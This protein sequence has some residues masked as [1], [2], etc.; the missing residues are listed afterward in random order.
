MQPKQ[1]T[2]KIRVEIGP[3]FP[4]DLGAYER[5]HALQ[6]LFAAF[7]QALTAEKVYPESFFIG[8][9]NGV[10][11]HLTPTHFSIGSDPNLPTIHHIECV[12]TVKLAGK[13][14]GELRPIPSEV[15]LFPIERGQL[16]AMKRGRRYEATVPVLPDISGRL[17]PGA[18]A[19]FYE[20]TANPLSDPIPVPEGDRLTV[21][22]TK[23][24]DADYP[25]VGHQL[26]FIAWD[27]DEAV[28][29]A[30]VTSRKSRR[31]TMPEK[32]DG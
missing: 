18:K 20:A 26:F 28:K 25:W 31:G 10:T 24:K 21:T 13:E 30:A 22:L 16:E 29:E 14:D 3:G 5:P 12:G 6:A 17:R 27:P 11:T 4:R 32:V 8:T 7:W 2:V 9:S 19:T 1:Q 15:F 23:V